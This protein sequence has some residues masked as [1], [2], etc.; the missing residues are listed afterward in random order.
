[1]N[2]IVPSR[3]SGTRH[4]AFVTTRLH[5]SE[6]ENLTETVKYPQQ[7]ET[8]SGSPRWSKGLCTPRPARKRDSAYK[9]PYLCERIYLS[10]SF[11]TKKAMIKLSELDNIPVFKTK[12]SRFEVAQLSNLVKFK[13]RTPRDRCARPKK[14]RANLGHLV[15]QTPVLQALQLDVC[16]SHVDHVEQLATS[17]GSGVQTSKLAVQRFSIVKSTPQP[18]WKFE[19]PTP[20]ATHPRGSGHFQPQHSTS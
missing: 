8:P 19:G 9:P 12:T 16:R 1:L 11:Q 7:D 5:G 3:K 14:K 13:T 17:R 10:I 2:C 4:C 20:L 15:A 6:P 18:I